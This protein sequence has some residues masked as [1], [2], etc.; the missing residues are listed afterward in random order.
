LLIAL[1]LSLLG[2]GLSAEEQ[3]KSSLRANN[4]DDRELG[5]TWGGRQIANNCASLYNGNNN[6]C[7]KT[8][9][10][11]CG[12]GNYCACASTN[13][14]G[15]KLVAKCSWCPYTPAGTTCPGDG[16]WYDKT[17]GP[18]APIAKAPVVPRAPVAPECYGDT[19]GTCSPGQYCRQKSTDWT[20][21]C[22]ACPTG[23]F[24]SGDGTRKSSTCG[25]LAAF[26]ADLAN[27]A[28]T[29]SAT[30]QLLAQGVSAVITRALGVFCPL[31]LQAPVKAP[32]KNPTRKP[33]KK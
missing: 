28:A 21:V 10:Q 3:V 17:Y 14:W 16:F 31:P 6:P 15:T 9:P 2:L 33:T 1:C 22:T 32:T 4:R 26:N 27:T 23:M 5:T 8:D 29:T 24:C 11:G 7:S 30:R 25:S 19:F 20:Y 18:P 12:V 13:Q